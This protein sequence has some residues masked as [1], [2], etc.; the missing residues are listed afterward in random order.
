M[1]FPIKMRFS[2]KALLIVLAMPCWAL[3]DSVVSKKDG[4]ELEDDGFPW[5]LVVE[6]GKILGCV[7]DS[8]FYSLGSILILESLPRKCEQASDRNG[9][10]QILS[11]QEMADFKRSIKEQEQAQR[12]VTF[13]GGK[14]LT[15]EE[16]RLI[17]FL[18][19]NKKISAKKSK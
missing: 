15:D 14:P 13:V 1:E 4:I 11:E 19:H 16:I 9:V 3:A 6:R 2:I 18:R 17:R 10:W 5:G 7:Y 12:E 8:R